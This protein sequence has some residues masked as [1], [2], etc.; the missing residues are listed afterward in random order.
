MNMIGACWM[1]RSLGEPI[2]ALLIDSNNRIIAGGWNGI[3][4]Q[5]S[6][7][8]DE[9]WSTQLP[10]RV[11]SITISKNGIF[12]CS[13]LHLVAINPDN[14]ALL[15]QHPLEGSADEVTTFNG[16]ILATSSVYDIEHN[17]FIDSAVWCFD[18]EGKKIWE[19]HM[20]ERPWAI[21]VSNGQVI[22]GLGRPKM[23][24]AIVDNDGNL[25]HLTLESKSPVTT[26]VDTTNGVVFG[27]ANGELTST[28]GKLWS[29]SGE[30][31][32]TICAIDD[33]H[34]TISQDKAVI[35]LN[36][37]FE[38]KWIEVMDP[39]S[40]ISS[41]IIVDGNFTIWAG[42]LNGSDGLLKVLSQSS[43]KL[44]SSMSCAKVTAINS[45]GKMI[46]VGD[47]KGELFVW[48]D[49]MFNRRL[50]S[51]ES[52]ENDEQRQSMRERLK[53]LRRR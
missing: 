16:L 45:N 44:I 7:E 15:W 23:G 17:D 38:Q 1:R 42:T 32:S 4:T 40:T 35:T 11:G 29:G 50:V 21:V 10:D 27:H 19:T 24:A 13:G 28:D 34:F 33:K 53:A 3:L 25:T 43:G 26:G 39:I 30:S 8:G 22:L 49:E 41:G 5:W 46:A 14:G 52:T 48:Q 20:D 9:L 37:D 51:N 2:S 12:V 6:A 31:I 18:S 47:E 36:S